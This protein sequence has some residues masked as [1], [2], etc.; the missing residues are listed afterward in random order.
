MGNRDVVG[1]KT[2]NKE[3]LERRSTDFSLITASK[4]IDRSQLYAQFKAVAT[5]YFSGNDTPPV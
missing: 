3:L 4:D 2:R 5:G 1:H